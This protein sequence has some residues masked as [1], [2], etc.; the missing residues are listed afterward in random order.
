M[1]R[2]L[3]SQQII[4][5]GFGMFG[6]TGEQYFAEVSKRNQE[7]KLSCMGDCSKPE[8]FCTATKET[9]IMWSHLMGSLILKHSLGK[10]AREDISQVI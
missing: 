7:R 2:E 9:R 8:Q 1:A 5:K 10:Q 4:K 3:V 6:L